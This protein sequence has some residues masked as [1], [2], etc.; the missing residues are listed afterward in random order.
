[1]F[2]GNGMIY[3]YF[4]SCKDGEETFYPPWPGLNTG[5][6]WKFGNSFNITISAQGNM[7]SLFVNGTQYLSKIEEVYGGRLGIRV[8][9]FYEVL[10]SGF[11]AEANR[12]IQLRDG[13]D[14]LEYVKN[15]GRL[16]VLNT[17]GYGYFANKILS[18]YNGTGIKS[19]VI[20]G[21]QS[22]KIPLSISVP[23]LY[24][25]ASVE[26]ISHYISQEGSVPYVLRKKECLGEIIYVNVYP[27]IEAMRISQEKYIFYNLLEELLKPAN[28]QLERFKYISPPI[29][30]IFK[31]I[32]ML[33][34]IWINA[35][36][37]IFPVNA[38][39][40]K[41]EIIDK[42]GKTLLLT[43]VTRL[44]VLNHGNVSI[45]SSDL[46][47][48]EGNGFYSNLRFKNN[49]TIIFYNNF[50]S[51]NLITKNGSIFETN[52]VKTIIISPNSNKDEVSL[53]VFKPTVS[54]KGTAYFKELYSSATIL[55]KTRTY[56][57]DLKVNGAVTLKMYLSDAYHLASLLNISGNSERSPPL[58]SYNELT[59][60]SQAG[61]LSIMLAPI[62]IIFALI[63]YYRRRGTLTNK[64]LLVA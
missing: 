55:L 26:I 19:S 43:N 52:S 11:K 12:F 47:L 23:I 27:I 34:D 61:F 48:S 49:V 38:N 5:L 59:S 35:S 10:F 64:E 16:I 53:Y 18:Y 13:N 29:M 41:V 46:I 24:P 57:Q 44:I 2:H 40:K 17:N 22:L 30:A 33:G 7:L 45:I 58:I 63:A 3:A 32:K 9:R 51:V 54:L 31:E 4:S 8:R 62:F 50:A 36:S 28:I 42:D 15:G 14:Y 6:K 21:F 25:K 20:N 37:I 60:L 1:M 39:F 56:G